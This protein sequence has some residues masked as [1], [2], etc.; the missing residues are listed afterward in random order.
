MSAQAAAPCVPFTGFPLSVNVGSYAGASDGESG[1]CFGTKVQ[2]AFGMM[3]QPNGIATLDANGDIPVSQ[4]PPGVAMLASP[5]F[6][7]F[8]TAPSINLTGSGSSGPGD[9]FT[10]QPTGATVART[11][12]DRAKD[13]GRN[14]RDFGAVCDGTTDN[15]PAFRAAFASGA[16]VV[17]YDLENCPSH[18][19][20]NTT[21]TI[22]GGASLVGP[23]DGMSAP[24][25]IRTTASVDTF[26]LGGNQFE[27]RDIYVLHDGTSGSAINAGS[28]QS[29]KILKNAFTGSSASNTSPLIY[30]TGSIVTISGNHFTNFRANGYAISI[31]GP[32]T[33]NPIVHRIVDN[34]FGGS[35]KGISI[36]STSGTTR[37]E[38]IY[39]ISNH[40]FL[41]NVCLLV[42]SVNDLRSVANTWDIGNVNQVVLAGSGQGIDLASFTDDYFSTLDNS[43]T[44]AVAR[45]GGVCLQVSGPVARLTVRSKFAYCDY[46]VSSTDGSA[47]FM[48]ISS[49]FLNVTNTALNLQNVKGVTL[50]GNTCASCAN[51]FILADGAS[52]GPYILN[53]N[54]WDPAGA[55]TITQTT[56][57]KFRFGGGN[58]G[59][60]LAGY[61][62]ATTDS[63]ATGTTCIG[64]AIPHGLKGTPNLDKTTLSP[65]AV[66]GAMT[67]ISATATAV[68]G[69]NITAQVCATVTTAGT[70]RVTANASL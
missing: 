25:G 62:A 18:Y 69:T 19:L 32:G 44:P 66:S 8:V 6:T 24:L 43:V 60:N 39:I 70:V 37:P 3:G 15:G 64:V 20:I 58:T 30:V 63:M 27:I 16:R 35:G 2:A 50:A 49:S 21:V 59:A 36:G 23:D 47:S 1:Y 53:E 12:A 34:N 68:D 42:N 61:S 57:G 9:G 48:T 38:G 31:N 45:T 65:R 11:I 40:C 54:Q 29:G 52:G 26:A 10:S 5:V 56:P 28:A 51:N 22:P 33:V 46:G 41:T 55:I 4:L 13:M 17:R 67:G 7:G 14:V